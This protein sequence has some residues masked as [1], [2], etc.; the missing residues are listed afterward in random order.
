[1]SQLIGYPNVGRFGLT[2]SLLAWARC[3]LWCADHG[4]EMLAPSW[5]HLRVGPYLRRERDKRAYHRLFQFRDYTTGARRLAL[6]SLAPRVNAEDV[7]L[8]AELARPGLRLVVFNNRRSE[9]EDYHFHHLVGRSAQVRQALVRMTKV[10][11]LPKPVAFPHIAVHIRMGDFKT[12]PSLDTVRAGITCARLPTGW[13]AEMIQALRAQLGRELPVR[14]YSDGHDSDLREVLGLPG[15]SR[16]GPCAAITDLLSIS[17]AS[18]F[19]SSGS[20][21]SFWGSYLGDVPRVCFPG[22]RQYRVLGEPDP[23]DREPECESGSEISTSFIDHVRQRLG[24]P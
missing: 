8:A 19:V 15:V 10:R 24:R 5:L 11:H 4:L 14:L 21:F 16:V 17:M 7:D 23:L 2:H 6:L 1:M 18:V 3:H 9:N 20:G 22:Q 13:Y 12:H